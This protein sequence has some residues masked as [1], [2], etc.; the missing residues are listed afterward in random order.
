MSCLWQNM[1]FVS[2]VMRGGL[3]FLWDRNYAFLF[4][5]KKKKSRQLCCGLWMSC[6]YNANY[7]LVIIVCFFHFRSIFEDEGMKLRQLKLENQVNDCAQAGKNKYRK[8]NISYLVVGRE[9]VKV[10]VS[11]FSS[12]LSL[13]FPL[14]FPACC[15]LLCNFLLRTT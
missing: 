5:K 7:F 2:S 12:F 1:K 13:I 14:D 11:F 10:L 3:A 9:E 8:T 15:H 6:S 4:L